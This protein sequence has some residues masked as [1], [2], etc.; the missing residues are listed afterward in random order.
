MDISKILKDKY[1]KLDLNWKS[2]PIEAYDINSSKCRIPSELFNIYNIS[3]NDIIIIKLNQNVW[4]DNRFI[5]Q[6]YETF[7]II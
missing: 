3:I 6:L 4:I 5:L 2:L 1:V 7:N